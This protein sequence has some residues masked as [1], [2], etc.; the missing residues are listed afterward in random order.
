M[1]ERLGPQ[2]LQ[3]KPFP[4]PSYFRGVPPVLQNLE[5][6]S[7]LQLF[8]CCCCRSVL[9]VDLA[10]LDRLAFEDELSSR[11]LRGDVPIKVKLVPPCLWEGPFKKESNELLLN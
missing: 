4:R 3:Q 9:S 8:C 10:L 1:W 5:F 6:L 7:F 11:A 2:I